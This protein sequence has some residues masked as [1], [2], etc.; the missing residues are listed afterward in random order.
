MEEIWKDIKEYEDLYQVSNLGRVKSILFRNN[1]AFIKKEKILT[2]TDNGKG[3]L[4]VGL[5]KNGLRKKQYV[6]RL[7]AQAFLDNKENYKEVNHKDCNTQNNSV[8]NLEWCTRS[9]NVKHSY[10]FGKHIPPRNLKGKFGY[11][12]PISKEISQYDLNNNYIQTY[13]SASQASKLTGICYESIKKVAR[14]KQHTAG[15]FVWKYTKEKV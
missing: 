7:V 6:H 4:I 11:D 2:P 8:D 14:N 15:G 12:H 10:V 9:Y 13:G 1:K 3:Y 5:C